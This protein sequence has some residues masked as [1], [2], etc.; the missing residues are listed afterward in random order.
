[1][2]EEGHSTHTVRSFQW[3]FPALGIHYGKDQTNHHM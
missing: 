3:E 2:L 1:M